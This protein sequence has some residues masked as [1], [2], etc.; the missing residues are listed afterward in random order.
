MK[1]RK[2]VLTMFALLFIVSTIIIS[3]CDTA[4][5]T[6]EYIFPEIILNSTGQTQD[7][8]I[9]DLE[10]K[11]NK[12]DLVTSV[13][14]GEDGS[15]IVE[16]TDKQ[17]EIWLDDIEKTIEQCEKDIQKIG[18]KITVNDERTDTIY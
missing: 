6:T 8:A 11:G 9:D 17:R 2:T 1:N 7:S 4:A 12:N 5:K 13:R 15:I 16:L 3:S 18:C 10:P 14:K